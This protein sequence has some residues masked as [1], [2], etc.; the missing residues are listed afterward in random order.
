MEVEEI[1]R[2][3]RRY[4]YFRFVLVTSLLFFFLSLIIGI[5]WVIRK[6]QQ[7]EEE[8]FRAP[9]KDSVVYSAHIRIYEADTGQLAA[10]V[11]GKEESMDKDAR[12][13]RVKGVEKAFFYEE[14]QKQGVLTAK[15]A[16]YREAMGQVIFSGSV[17][18]L[19]KDKTR[20]RADTV[21][22][23]KYDRVL[24]FL[25]GGKI[26][27]AEGNQLQAEFGILFPKQHRMELFSRIRVLVKG[28]RKIS[29][30]GEYLTY[31]QEW[32]RL[33]VYGKEEAQKQVKWSQYYLRGF[34]LHPL[35]FSLSDAELQSGNEKIQAPTIYFD[36]PSKMGTVYN[37]KVIVSP[38][39]SQ[40]LLQAEKLEFYW[41]L[42]YIFTKNQVSLTLA[43]EGWVLSGNEGIFVEKDQTFKLSGNI[44]AQGREKKLLPE[45]EGE[46][47]LS[48]QNLTIYLPSER[49]FAEG[50]VVVTEGPS[51]MEASSL[52]F[53]PSEEKTTA[54]FAHFSSPTTE[55]FAKKW[56]IIEGKVSAEGNVRI[57]QKEPPSEVE[58]QSLVWK[59]A[60]DFELARNVKGTYRDFLF[61][62]EE[63]KIRGE[64][65][66]FEGNVNLQEANEFSLQAQK[67]KIVQDS[68]SAEGN[69]LV[70]VGDAEIRGKKMSK[71]G[72][73]ILLSEWVSFLH[74][75][76]RIACDSLEWNTAEKKGKVSG[77][78]EVAL[79]KNLVPENW[80]E[81]ESP[82][83]TV[84]AQNLD[85]TV[86]PISVS[87]PGNSTILQGKAYGEIQDLYWEETTGLKGAHFLLRSSKSFLK[88]SKEFTLQGEKVSSTPEEFRLE[89]KVQF[90][91][92]PLE[93][94]G[95]SL[96][97][98]SEEWEMQGN[99]L[100][101]IRKK[102]ET[103]EI[104]TP[105][106]TGNS[107]AGIISMDGGVQL[108]TAKARIEGK[109]GIYSRK[110]GY[111]Q[112]SDEITVQY[113]DGMSVKASAFIYDLSTGE[114]RLEQSEGTITL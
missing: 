3:Q 56:E 72:N 9:E 66:F 32:Q 29:L 114:F 38:K 98:R 33:T 58:A 101:S 27:D 25:N 28:E 8:M 107:E 105:H 42:G 100:L 19:L 17:S 16:E 34:Q 22:W 24:I 53:L 109:R 76:V 14:G 70:R 67:T 108:Q 59:G 97:Y 91:E 64:E 63:V 85:F 60:Q 79:L 82:W 73:H 81:A 78:Q 4:F 68:V 39:K 106:I 92:G 30:K 96:V 51:R 86:E 89:G 15:R 55:M 44:V 113:T 18:I 80:T 74:P 111:F 40:G 10:E 93:I 48:A 88:E 104:K 7:V 102:G 87:I 43:K 75:S 1:I 57:K 21:L 83:S 11:F 23:N 112:I 41:E 46:T 52:F 12:I 99:V 37:G 50:S 65:V 69:L 13:T 62:A 84:R 20:I 95:D 94:S 77:A 90:T 49:I 5:I 54:E 61:Q 31:Q 71:K 45:G 6:S 2:A 35:P 110:E 36:I 26:S 47:I 103:L